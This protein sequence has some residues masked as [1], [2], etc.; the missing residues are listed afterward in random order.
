MIEKEKRSSE[1]QLCGGKYLVGVKGPK[2]QII[3]LLIITAERS[4]VVVD[5]LI[6]V[7]FLKQLGSE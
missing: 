4:A 2:L 1:Q 5:R 6:V 7:Y 3:T